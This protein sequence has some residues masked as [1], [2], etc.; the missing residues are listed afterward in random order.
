MECG[1][2]DHLDDPGLPLDEAYEMRLK[3]IEAYDQAGFY[4]YHLA[5]HHATPLGISPSPG[6]FL[7]AVAQ[8]THHLRFGPLVY[9]LQFYHPIRLIEEICML[10]Q[11]SGGRFQLGV[12]KGVSPIELRFYGVDPAEASALYAEELEVVLRGLATGE[13]EGAAGLYTLPHVALTLRPKQHPH[14]PLWYGISSPESTVWAAKHD[15]HIVTLAPAPGARVITDRYRQE[16]SALGKSPATLPF[17]GV[18]RQIVVAESDE[19]ARAIARRAYQ[20]WRKAFRH[21][22]SLHGLGHVPDKLYPPDFEDA[23]R[24]G[25]AVAGAPPF[26][27]DFIVRHMEECG[28]TY[29]AAAFAFGDMTLGEALHSIDLFARHIMPVLRCHPQG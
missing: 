28:A 15:V 10:D 21:L 20:R 3:L 1:V 16:W 9:P 29:L 5:E 13:V 2:F 6:V 25:M 8:R 26:V 23:Q 27:R 14:P 12:G 19:L 18:E 4:A 7:A 17:L 11:L 22:W 24:A